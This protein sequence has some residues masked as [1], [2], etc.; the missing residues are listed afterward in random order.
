MADAIYD[1]FGTITKEALTSIQPKLEQILY[2]FANNIETPETKALALE[3]N[4]LKKMVKTNIYQPKKRSQYYS[5]L[6]NTDG[7]YQFRQNKK[8]FN[9]AHESVLKIRNILSGFIAPPKVAIYKMFENG[10]IKRITEDDIGNENL[11]NASRS[12]TNARLGLSQEQLKDLSDFTDIQI[13][14]SEHFLDAKNTID[15]KAK[16]EPTKW[17]GYNR[18]HIAEAFEGHFQHDHDGKMQE[19]YES[20][21][22]STKNR[23]DLYVHFWYAHKNK[24]IWY[25]GGDIGDWQVKFLGDKQQ[26]ISAASR[27]SLKE[28]VTYVLRILDKDILLKMD[29]YQIHETANELLETFFVTA[30]VQKDYK[31]LV[32]EQFISPLEKIK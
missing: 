1:K 18:G 29:K 3:I 12:S 6:N 15:T 25:K 22:S 32:D 5:Y 20:I 9:E 4:N 17:G 7:I 28:I 8:Y 11:L 23:Q 26:S 31:D 21:I 19:H 13:K 2:D 27:L 24:D 10:Q 14:F 30:D 16:D